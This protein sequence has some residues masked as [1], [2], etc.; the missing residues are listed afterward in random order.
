[1]KPYFFFLIFIIGTKSFGQITLDFANN[2]EDCFGYMNV[3]FGFTDVANNPPYEAKLYIDNTSP[4]PDF[5]VDSAEYSTNTISGGFLYSFTPA[6]LILVIKSSTGDSVFTTFFPT[7]F[8][9]TVLVTDNSFY[10]GT[11]TVSAGG[12][13]P[14]YTYNLYE[15]GNYISSQST[16]LFVGLTAGN[17]SAQVED[18]YGCIES[19]SY[20]VAGNGISACSQNL[21]ASISNEG[22]FQ[23]CNGSLIWNLT[24]AHPDSTFTMIIEGPNNFY[25]S[26]IIPAGMSVDTISNLCQG[27]YKFYTY[28]DLL[29]IDTAEFQVSGPTDSLNL[30]LDSH[31]IPSIGGS[32]GGL[33]YSSSGGTAPYLY[34]LN[35]GTYQQNATYSNL[36]AGQYNIQVLDANGCSKYASFFLDDNASIT[37]KYNPIIEIFPNP[38]IGVVNVLAEGN[39]SI[40]II[41]LKGSIALTS[42][43]ED[44]TTIDLSDIP[45]GAYLVR[46]VSE[47]NIYLNK[48]I[49]E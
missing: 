14:P 34:S 24:Q 22:C 7:Y 38:A 27:Q 36:S 26:L 35:G 17:Y 16:P 3:N 6:P 2:Y 29:C 15:S 37:D 32:D 8:T 31:T 1:M 11:V 9:M 44:K 12:G 5:L 46:L 30:S 10:D 21:F 13:Q 19:N 4:N 41:D 49:V 20:W 39:Y 23:N 43:F 45:P 25:D 33:E 28:T 18:S 47:A 40:E 48:L 42:Y